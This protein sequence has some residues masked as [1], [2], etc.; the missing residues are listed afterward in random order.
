MVAIDHIARV[1]HEVNRGICKAAG[2]H[3]QRP[4]DEAEPWQRDSARKGVAYAL[5]NPG[6][7]AKD[8]HDAWMA[9]KLAAGWVY[10]PVK[11][12]N[13]LTHPC[14]VPYDNLS[15]ADRVKDYAF[16]AVVGSMA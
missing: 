11:D 4:W 1:A 9:D 14:L 7:T 6:A 10:G 15:F 3:S 2:D 8:Q 16:R 5:A 13:V 12:A